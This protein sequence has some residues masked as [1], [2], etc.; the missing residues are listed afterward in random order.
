VVQFNKWGFSFCISNKEAAPSWKLYNP[1]TGCKLVISV[2][3]GKFELLAKD[4]L[5]VDT[6]AIVT[7][8]CFIYGFTDRKRSIDLR[9]L[10]N[11]KVPPGLKPLKAK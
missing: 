3:N 2:I 5:L 8:R 7:K 11:V 9:K 1:I 4:H 10:E 6:P